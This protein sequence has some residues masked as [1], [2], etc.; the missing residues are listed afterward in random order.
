MTRSMEDSGERELLPDLAL[1][2]AVFI[3]GA[4]FTV[5][6]QSL[7]YTTPFL[8]LTLR[9]ALALA[10]ITLWVAPVLRSLTRR[11][12]VGGVLTG[13][14][15]F[16]GFSFQTWG[17]VYTSASK[18]AFITG[19][20][21]V[22]VPFF[23]WGITRRRI[24]ASRWAAAGMATLGLFM[25]TDPTGAAGLNRGDLLTVGCAF[26]FAGQI[27]FLGIYAP[28]SHTL[29]YFWVQLATMVALAAAATLAVGGWQLTPSTTLWWGLG[30]TGVV[31]TAL[32]FLA[33]TWAQRRTSP[34]RTALI[35]TMEPVFGAGFAVLAAGEILP[36]TAWLG[37]ALIVAAILWA[38]VRQSKAAVG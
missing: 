21:V 10:I 8:F 27:I 15:L 28:T 6:K 24:R 35:L 17:L 32:A 9:F 29:R 23:L 33:Q 11:E 31:A 3:W 12:L 38:E 4:T 7:Q 14:A 36:L 30:V 20:N 18:S 22:L 5:V 26:A 2:L 13:G 1:L 19:L 37:G 34:T 25:L 16:L